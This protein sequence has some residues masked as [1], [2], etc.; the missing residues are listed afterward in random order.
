MKQN[1]F[2]RS[3]QIVSWD[4]INLEQNYIFGTFWVVKVH[5]GLGAEV[6]LKKSITG[7]FFKDLFKSKSISTIR[8]FKIGMRGDFEEKK[9]HVR[10]GKT[11]FR[12]HF[13]HLFKFIWSIKAISDFGFWKCHVWKWEKGHLNLPP[14]WRMDLRTMHQKWLL[15]SGK[16][17]KERYSFFFLWRG[18]GVLAKG[19]SGFDLELLLKNESIQP[20]DNF[21]LI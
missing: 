3:V 2:L 10:G 1:I 20:K 13:P 15:F 6:R 16:F 18:G 8:R 4:E 9:I 12:D 11:L 14:D 7:Y 19:N 17:P 21:F 5:M